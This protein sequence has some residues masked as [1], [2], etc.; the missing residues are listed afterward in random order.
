MAGRRSSI[1]SEIFGKRLLEQ[2]KIAG[3]SQAVVGEKL[4]V[5]QRMVA[6]YESKSP[7]PSAE[8]VQQLAELF[9]VSADTFFEAEKSEE[10]RKPG[11]R[12]NL[13]QRVD[14]IKKLPRRQQDL[15]VALLDAF[16]AQQEKHA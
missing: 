12:S 11:P 6:Y 4:G 16:L 5:S 3:F 9:E 1:R 14:S 2:R 15:V 10:K 7:Q 8:L 13:D